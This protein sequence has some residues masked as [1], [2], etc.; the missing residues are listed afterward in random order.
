MSILK[1]PSMVQ[2]WETI[3]FFGSKANQ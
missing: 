3:Q 1:I 2:S